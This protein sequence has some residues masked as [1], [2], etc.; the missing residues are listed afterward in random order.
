MRSTQ[1]SDGKHSGRSHKQTLSMQMLCAVQLEL[2]TESEAWFRVITHVACRDVWITCCSLRFL[3]ALLF[4]AL[5]RVLSSLLSSS[6]A[7]GAPCCWALYTSW[8]ARIAASDATC[9]HHTSFDSV[10]NTSHL[11]LGRLAVQRFCKTQCCA[12][13]AVCCLDIALMMPQ[14][15]FT[16]SVLLLLDE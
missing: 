2:V 10:P 7:L 9:A 6:A 13:A 1:C 3:P 14:Q 11:Q 16:R 4:L 15:H 12:F 5:R 8:G